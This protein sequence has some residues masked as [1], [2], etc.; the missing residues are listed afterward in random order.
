MER[1]KTWIKLTP[2]EELAVIREK[3][4]TSRVLRG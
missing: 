1:I 2:V 3:L 4:E